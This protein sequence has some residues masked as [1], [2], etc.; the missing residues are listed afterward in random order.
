VSTVI[1]T[2]YRS[3]IRLYTILTKC[4]PSQTRSDSI[5]ADQV[6]QARRHAKSESA[7]TRQQEKVRVG[8]ETADL[9]A[10]FP[11]IRPIAPTFQVKTVSLHFVGTL[12]EP[13]LRLSDDPL[14]F[15]EIQL[16]N[17]HPRSQEYEIGI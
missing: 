12:R 15:I 4:Q 2:T 8:S 10:A 3:K 11:E 5:A 17:K 13:G 14:L 7:N 16:A 1:E 9:I 6:T